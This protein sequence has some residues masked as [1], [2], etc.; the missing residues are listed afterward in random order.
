MQDDRILESASGIHGVF[1]P[2]RNKV[3]MTFLKAYLPGQKQ[4]YEDYTISYNL[5]TQTFESF[6]DDKPASWLNS[7]ANLLSVN[8]DNL[9]EGWLSHE[10][11]KNNFYGTVYDS[12]IHIIINPAADI[13]CIMD[14]IQYK[15]E[16]FI[17]DVD[18]SNI[19]L[20]TL[21][22][23]NDHQDSGVINLVVGENVVRKFRS[24]RMNVPRDTKPNDPRIRDYYMKV[25]LKHNPSNNERMVLHD[26]I[27]GYRPSP[28]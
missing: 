21:Q 11:E 12:E 19:T 7:G 23:L 8:P 20:D 2:V 27:T 22:V 6:S 14:S 1:D 26:I 3:V 25:I 4:H 24:W 9:S 18:Q 15:G 5:N 10:G 28:H 16:M 17:N 13:T